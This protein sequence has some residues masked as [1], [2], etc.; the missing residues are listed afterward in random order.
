MWGLPRLILMVLF[1][2][3]QTTSES[4]WQSATPRDRCWHCSQKKKKR[5]NR[6]PVC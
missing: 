5:N 6:C 1:V 4:E 3:G 2:G